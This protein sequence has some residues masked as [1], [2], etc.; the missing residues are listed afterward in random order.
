MTRAETESSQGVQP[1]R[2]D[3]SQA[4]SLLGLSDLPYAGAAASR[5]GALA[6]LRL[7]ERARSPDEGSE[8]PAQTLG[9]RALAQAGS[10]GKS[11][12]HALL[13]QLA[14]EHDREVAEARG[15]QQRLEATVAPPPVSQPPAPPPPQPPIT[16]PPGLA[17]GFTPFE[18]NTDASESCYGHEFSEVMPTDTMPN[19]P[20]DAS[21]SD[22]RRTNAGRGVNGL[23]TSLNFDER[24]TEGGGVSVT[25]ART[26]VKDTVF[27]LRQLF[28]ESQPQPPHTFNDFSDLSFVKKRLSEEKKVLPVGDARAESYDGCLKRI[29]SYPGSPVRFVWDTFGAFLIGYD[30]ITIPLKV[31][32]PEEVLL[33]IIFEWTSLVYWTIN[34]PLSL[35]VGFVKDGTTVMHP[36]RVFLHYLRTWFLVDFLV[37]V[38]EWL[39]KIADVSGEDMDAGT[40]KLLRILRFVRTLR[41]LR[42]MKL[43]VLL[44]RVNDLLDSEYAG[45]AFNIIKMIL[46]LLLINH[47]I[48]CAFFFTADV[49]H[50]DADALT[51]V[52]AHHF[53]LDSW[54]YKYF[55]AFHWSI[56]QFTPAS[57]HVQPQNMLERIFA[58]VVVVGALVGF[59]YLV[60]S[61]TGSLTQLR[62]MQED[63]SRQFWTLRRFLRQQQISMALSL[64]V[65]QYVE[66]AWS[67]QKRRVGKSSVKIFSLLSD[68]LDKELQCESSVPHVVCHPLFEYLK[69]SSSVTMQRL[70][71]NAMSRKSFARGD[72]LFYPGEKATHMIFVVFGRLMY[73]QSDTHKEWVDKGEDWISEPVLW[74][75]HWAHIGLLTA[76]VECEL[77]LVSP[78]EFASLVK[79]SPPVW[80]IV[81]RYG[82]N[83][84]RWLNEDESGAKLSD[85]IQ[86]EDK[87]D[88]I[89]NLIFATT[90]TARQHGSAEP[91]ERNKP[92][93]K[94]RLQSLGFGRSA[95]SNWGG[96]D[97][98]HKASVRS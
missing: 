88:E 30:L 25:Q 19:V 48:A 42:F 70:A 90:E 82:R 13:R 11:Q 68:Q 58:L 15:G 59:S 33:T 57:M 3:G 45:I 21:H 76:T 5:P 50:D 6:M 95:S 69:E 79:L 56:T 78:D 77:L 84:V 37:V 61:I 12:F 43:Q 98:L 2:S 92:R 9:A 62:A 97:I 83:F 7:G 66:H 22:G 18:L 75:D 53:E 91:V 80:N 36:G 54:Q 35:T 34:M 29:M 94:T 17:R 38:P 47:F 93:R 64:R 49:Q 41:L 44:A 85:V 60:G 73:T 24:L 46:A 65:T 63:S 10:G 1:C 16:K 86:G 32:N 96:L 72:S 67:Q 74:T 27:T 51:W 14:A 39:T 23:K 81:C 28:E 55:T 87:G 20:V 26:M 71:T 8:R 52:R 40:V 4:Q 89:R 31:F